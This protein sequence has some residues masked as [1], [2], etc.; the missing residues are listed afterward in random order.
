VSMN[1]VEVTRFNCTSLLRGETV[2]SLYANDDMTS[3]HV[4]IPSGY[5]NSG[6]VQYF[7]NLFS[8]FHRRGLMKVQVFLTKPYGPFTVNGNIRYNT[9][10]KHLQSVNITFAKRLQSV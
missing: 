2:Y 3:M 6:T 7:Q 1:K 10:I 5:C 8:V 4:L 9:F